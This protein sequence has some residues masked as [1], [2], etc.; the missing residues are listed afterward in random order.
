VSYGGA[1]C[2]GVVD[3]R[4]MREKWSVILLGHRTYLKAK[5]GGEN[6]MFGKAGNTE[7]ASVSRPVETRLPG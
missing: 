1:P 6:S 2:H 4:I 3:P 7:T 5:A